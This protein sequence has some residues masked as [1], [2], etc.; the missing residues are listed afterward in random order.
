MD[1]FDEFDT[2]IGFARCPHGVMMGSDTGGAEA[3]LVHGLIS[4]VSVA[5]EVESQ[6]LIPL[7]NEPKLLEFCSFAGFFVPFCT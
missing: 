3:I 5:A 1:E 7:S 2:W 4:F 6:L